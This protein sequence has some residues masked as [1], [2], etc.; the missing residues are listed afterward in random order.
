VVIESPLALTPSQSTLF[1]PLC[2]EITFVFF[3]D[4]KKLLS[5]F[6]LMKVYY[7]TLENTRGIIKT[8]EDFT[9]SQK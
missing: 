1:K 7:K 4:V 5:F 8:F 6:M 2:F 9:P 3:P